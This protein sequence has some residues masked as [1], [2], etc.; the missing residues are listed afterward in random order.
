MRRFAA[1][2]ATWASHLA[3]R[4]LSHLEKTTACMINL[5]PWTFWLMPCA[6]LAFKTRITFEGFTDTDKDLELWVEFTD[7]EIVRQVTVDLDNSNTENEEPLPAQSTSSEL[8]QSL[9]TLSS[10]HSNDMTLAKIEANMIASKRN[11]AQKR[12]NN[13]FHTTKASNIDQAEDGAGYIDCTR[14]RI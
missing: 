1:A 7:H 12:I 9:M 2:F 6:P 8:R 10:E 13:F 14:C 3:P 5:L 11:A 4:R